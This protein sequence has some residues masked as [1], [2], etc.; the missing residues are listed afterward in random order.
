MCSAAT[1]TQCGKTTWRGCGQHVDSVMAGV[2]TDQRCTCDH[3]SAAT[4]G[5]AVPT[6]RRWFS[7]G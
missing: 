6:K 5:T 1:C 7:R 3:R 4:K 2:P